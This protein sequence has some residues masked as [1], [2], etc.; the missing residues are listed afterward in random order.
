MKT[1]LTN[2]KIPS[3]I[4]VGG[5]IENTA[6]RLMVTR[7][8]QGKIDG[9]KIEMDLHCKSDINGVQIHFK[10]TISHTL[11]DLEMDNLMIEFNK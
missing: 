8:T 11:T 2:V 6:S 4:E 3:K 5:G 7:T 10:S 9:A 1:V